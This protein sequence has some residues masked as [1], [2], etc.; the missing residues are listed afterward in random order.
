MLVTL[1][2]CIM[3][4]PT[5]TI[6]RI[7]LLLTKLTLRLGLGVLKGYHDSGRSRPM[8]MPLALLALSLA[9]GVARLRHVL[10]RCLECI[11]RGSNRSL[12][13][14]RLGHFENTLSSC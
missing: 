11:R 3:P 6:A 14:L 7:L 5:A 4:T 1:G 9:L 8:T 2:L 10:V 12:L 13:T